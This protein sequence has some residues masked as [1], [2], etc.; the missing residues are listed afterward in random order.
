[1]PYE[2][3]VFRR[4]SNMFA[5]P[6]LDKVHPLGKSPVVS[7][8]LPP[9]NPAAGGQET[10]CRQLVLAES[11][12]IAQYLCE[13]F[14]RAR[15]LLPRRYRDGQEG[16][17]GGETEGWLRYQYFLH[18]AEGS[19]MPP[20]LVALILQSTSLS[21]FVFLCL[22]HSEPSLTQTDRQ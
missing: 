22:Y 10:A 5:P 8:A 17:V 19:L 16:V 6:E 2:V 20:L 21:F 18:Y 15:N 3:E 7:I 1:M 12:F 4:T 11:G 14:G 9:A 13:H